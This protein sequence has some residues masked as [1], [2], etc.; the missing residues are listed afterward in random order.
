[1]KQVFAAIQKAYIWGVTALSNFSFALIFF[2]AIWMGVDVVGRSVFNHPIAGTPELVK[3]A[4][5]AIVFLSFAYTLRQKRHVNVEIITNM[6]PRFTRQLFGVFRSFFG[7][8]IFAVITIASWGPAWSGWLN[9]EYEGV[10][11]EVPVYPVR[12]IIFFGAGIFATQYFIDM[13]ASIR[14]M[15]KN[16]KGAN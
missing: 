2:I 14:E 1:M 6:M 3:S 5:P 8:A 10:Q 4:L 16:R 11:L 9:K 12:F 13:V 7:W 15:L